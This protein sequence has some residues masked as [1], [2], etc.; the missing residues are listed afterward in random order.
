MNPEGREGASHVSVWIEDPRAAGTASAK[1]LKHKGECLQTPAR[2]RAWL[3]LME[4]REGGDRKA[5][6]GRG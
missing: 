2:R 6:M 5:V 3:E 1:V 4:C